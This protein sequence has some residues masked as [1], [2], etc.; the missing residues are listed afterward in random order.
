MILNTRKYRLS[1]I[2]LTKNEMKL[3]LLLSDN[4]LHKM[5]E[6]MEYLNVWGSV[7]VF[8]V[9]K[10]INK[11]TCDNFIQNKRG[12]GYRIRAIIELDY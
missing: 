12:H 10:S 5:E 3:I 1:D 2:D 8:R 9:I 4:K 11:K 7:C 6:C